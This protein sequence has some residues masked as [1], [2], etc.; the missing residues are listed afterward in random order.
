MLSPILFAIF[1]NDL[2]VKLNELNVGV[3]I[4][5]H[6]LNLLMYADDIV[7]VSPTATRCS[8]KVVSYLGDVHKCEKV[9]G[10]PRMTTS[11]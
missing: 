1:I 11:T 10:Y 5:E 8:D 6:R 3:K 7:K 2:G 4:S 9:A